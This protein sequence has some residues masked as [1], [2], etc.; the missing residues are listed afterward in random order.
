METH[1]GRAQVVVV[2]LED[3]GPAWEGLPVAAQAV[4]HLLGGAIVS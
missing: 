3:L 4:L 2:E 1:L